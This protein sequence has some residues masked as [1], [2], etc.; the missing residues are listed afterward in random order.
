MTH[1]THIKEIDSERKLF[2]AFKQNSKY[3]LKQHEFFIQICFG[4]EIHCDDAHGYAAMLWADHWKRRD[5]R[6]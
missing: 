5:G 6:G 1:E 3:V 2:C 4:F